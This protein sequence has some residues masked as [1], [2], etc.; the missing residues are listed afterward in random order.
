MI[1]KICAYIM[2]IGSL[3]CFA[4]PVIAMWLIDREEKKK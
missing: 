1:I 3:F 2:L 4:C